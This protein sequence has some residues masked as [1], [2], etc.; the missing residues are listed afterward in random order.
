MWLV[1][2]TGRTKRSASDKSFKYMGS[3]RSAAPRAMRMASLAFMRA[4]CWRNEKD[5]DKTSF[6]CAPIR[7]DSFYY[8]KTTNHTND[9]K[10]K[11]QRGTRKHEIMKA[12]KDKLFPLS[13]FRS[14]VLSCF[15]S[16]VSFV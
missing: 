4:S 3:N 6:R 9:T 1:L 13:R 7:L 15:S 14:F 16:F 11:R 12:Q 8:R 2:G 5:T 10:K